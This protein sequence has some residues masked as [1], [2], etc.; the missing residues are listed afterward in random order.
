MHGRGSGVPLDERGHNTLD[1]RPFT[2]LDGRP[3][4]RQRALAT[5]LIVRRRGYWAVAAC[6]SSVPERTCHWPC[7]A[8]RR[9]TTCRR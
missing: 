9:A 7:R 3:M 2:D 5:E 8:A 1:V 6:V 4:D